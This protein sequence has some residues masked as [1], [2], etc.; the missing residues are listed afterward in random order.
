MD[1]EALQRSIELTEQLLR[2]I[3]EEKENLP[4]AITGEVMV[5]WLEGTEQ[6]EKRAQQIKCQLV[7]MQTALTSGL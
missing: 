3:A 2:Q 6:A 1:L 5:S 4:R 7:D